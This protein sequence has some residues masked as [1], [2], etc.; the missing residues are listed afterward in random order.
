MPCLYHELDE[1]ESPQTNN[2]MPPATHQKSPIHRRQTKAST[3]DFTRVIIFCAE[4]N[5]K[6][7]KKILKN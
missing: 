1:I 3:S 5:V 6:Y 2:I 7:F 4:K